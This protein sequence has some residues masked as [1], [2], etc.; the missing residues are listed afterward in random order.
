VKKRGSRSCLIESEELVGGRE[1]EQN[2]TKQNKTKQNKTKQNK[3]K[4]KT[5]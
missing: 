5:G 3:T 4:K 1:R 2:K